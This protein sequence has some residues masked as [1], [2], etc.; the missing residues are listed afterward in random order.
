MSRS[1]VLVR[2]D[3][4]P[5]KG[6]EVEEVL[7]LALAVVRRD[8]SPSAWF[9]LR[10]GR[11]DYGIVE[12]FPEVVGATGPD[13]RPPTAAGVLEEAHALLA[14]PIAVQRLTVLAEKVPVMAPVEAVTK[15]LLLR[16]RAKSGHEPDVERFLADARTT[17]DGEPETTAW[18]A[19]RL[20]DGE[21]G[22]FDVFPD[23]RGRFAHLTGHVPRELAK[24]AL[25]LLGSVPDLD[26]IQVV[27]AH[28][29]PGGA[30]ETPL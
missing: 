15:A 1:G 5:D 11:S 10:F 22:I 9:G 24:H 2:L 12:L 16:F 13:S 21:Y 7:R 8:P 19:L 17:V 6:A 3:T 23:A 25:T 14:A 27:A 4:R 28:M 18:F 30:S 29:G 20:D 26:M